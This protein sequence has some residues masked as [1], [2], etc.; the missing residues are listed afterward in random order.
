MI[1]YPLDSC[2]I[3]FDLLEKTLIFVNRGFISIYF[4]YISA[5]RTA[6]TGYSNEHGHGRRIEFQP[7]TLLWIDSYVKCLLLEVTHYN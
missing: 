3:Y 4:G 2:G 5:L 1:K 7:Q 6:Q